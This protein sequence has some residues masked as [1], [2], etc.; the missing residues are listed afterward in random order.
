MTL[1]SI[2]RPPIKRDK[3]CIRFSMHWK[4][5]PHVK[6]SYAVIVSLR[7]IRCSVHLINSVSFHSSKSLPTY[8]EERQI[9]IPGV[10]GDV[11]SLNNKK[12][13]LTVISLWISSSYQQGNLLSDNRSAPSWIQYYFSFLL[14]HAESQTLGTD[15][16]HKFLFS[17]FFSVILLFPSITSRWQ[18][19]PISVRWNKCTESVRLQPVHGCCQLFHGRPSVPD[20]VC[21]RFE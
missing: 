10:L 18:T 13:G 1:P 15:W 19:A 17:S 12:Q 11:G 6:F 4:W 8:G 20:T 2:Y 5:F 21:R 16:K 7:M 9:A 3:L 14:S